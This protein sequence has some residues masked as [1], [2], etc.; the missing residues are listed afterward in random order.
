M[1][2]CEFKS[3]LISRVSSKPVRATQRNNVFRKKS[4]KI[5]CLSTPIPNKAIDRYD[6]VLQN[7]ANVHICVIAL[8]GNLNSNSVLIPTAYVNN[9]S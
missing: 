2:F 5:I 6:L 8:S 1:D 7:G 9:S 4:Y 3:N